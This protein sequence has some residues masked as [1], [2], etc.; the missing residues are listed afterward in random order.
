MV[1][2]A[3]LLVSL[4]TAT[5][6]LNDW[7]IPC[8]SGVCSYDIPDAAGS[9]S[10]S[11]K[12]WGSNDAISDITTAAGWEIIGCSPDK[13]SQDI[14]LVCTSDDSKASGCSHLYDNAGP[15]G[16]IVRLPQ[17]CGKNAFARVAR[18]WVPEDQ[19]IPSSIAGKIVR[20]DGTQPE[21]KALAL[22]TN[23]KAIDSSKTGPVNFAVKGAN[24]KGAAGDIDTSTVSPARR[25]RIY[26]NAERGLF[27]FVGDAIDAI[28]GLNDFDVDNSKA[29]SP[30][31]VNKN[32]NLLD[33]QLSCPPITGSIKIDVDAKAN[34][35]ATI[36]VAASGTIIP[37]KVKDFA[38][39]TSLTADID[40]AVTMVA[41][42]SG[43]LDSGKIKIFE[44]GVPGLDFPGILTLGPTFEVNAQAT[45]QLDIQADMTVG[46]NYHV[47]KAQ[48]IFPPNSKKA[49]AAGNAFSVGDTP[50]K[51]SVAP[52]VKATGTVGA[53]FIPSLNLKVAALGDI[54]NAGI[55]LE[56]DASAEMI[57]SLE[58]SVQGSITVDKAKREEPVLK[59]RYWAPNTLPAKVAA[60]DH[61]APAPAAPAS[62]S[63]S[64]PATVNHA[65][66]V[67]ATSAKATSVEAEAVTSV[68]A[69]STSAAAATT[70]ADVGTKAVPV[71]SADA[72]APVATLPAK[73]GNLS[74]V[75]DSSASFG[76]CFKVNAG[77]DVNA[78][79]DA[80]FFG[81]FDTG[82]KVSLFSK[83]F[84]ILKKC[85]G[86][87]K[88]SLP[89]PSKLTRATLQKRA[90][91]CSP[92]DVGAAISVADQIVQAGTIIAV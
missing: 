31:S 17:A 53:H 60:E 33:Q 67:E 46:L 14:R 10:G 61:M 49:Q 48:L 74:V 20:R 62:H 41:T 34:A 70:P 27:D 77:L 11:L 84:E 63:Q 89:L 65:S 5:H 90:L 21:V 58:G 81:L 50:L 82:T 69:P 37:P 80:N 87:A 16:K 88:R 72:D 68:K 23:F 12:I 75:K 18:A 85:F 4:A 47:E 54:V 71:S 45:A 6:A 86:N 28:K 7:S 76:G 64:K 2:S 56:L 26:G 19:S 38:I 66:S 78:G 42:A 15:E 32:F 43:T 3:I 57:L 35:V 91:T 73:T 8:L 92:A 9:S 24:I 59:G 40:G 83:K 79:A 22:D 1:Y 52:N 39:I 36:G 29:L 13:L 30:L 55:F 25:S 51:L 44:V